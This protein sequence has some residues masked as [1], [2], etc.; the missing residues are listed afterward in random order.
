MGIASNQRA[1]GS[2]FIGTTTATRRLR[3]RLLG[4]TAVAVAGLIGISSP[5]MAQQALPDAAPDAADDQASNADDDDIIV[6]TARRREESLLQVPV[7]VTALSQD[8]LADLQAQ[9]LGG[10]QGAVP[11]LNLVQGRGSATSANIFIRGV[12]QPDALQTFDPAVGVY[13]DG[14]FLSRIQGALLTLSDVER[15]EVLRGPQGTLYG[16][17]TIGGAVNIISRKP[18]LNEF[19]AS[20]SFLY[21]SFDQ[22]TINGYASVPLAEDAVA[23]SVAGQYDNR[24]GIITNPLTGERFNDRDN[25]TFRSIL[26]AQPS[27]SVELSLSGDYTRQRNALTLGSP[28]APIIQTDFLTGPR[29]LVPANQFGPFDFESATSFTNGEGQE[30]DHWGIALTA[31]FQLSDSLELVSITS[32]RDLEADFFIDID[33][34]Q[35]EIGD[36]F[37]GIDQRQW[38]QELQLR[39]S[40]DRL[41]GV[42]GLYYLNERVDSDQQAFADDL[43][44]FGG[45]PISFERLINDAQETDSYAVFGQLT[46]DISDY[47]AITAGLRYTYEEKRYN[48]FTTTVSDLALLNGIDFSFPDDLPPPLNGTDTQDFDAFTPSLTIS[49]TPAPDRLLYASASRGF[50]SGGFNG[51]ANSLADLTLFVD[52]APQLVTTFEPETV[53]TYE[54]GGKASFLDGDVVVSAAVF[55]SDY[56][57]FQARVGGGVDGGAGVGVF[58]VLNAGELEIFGFEIEATAKPIEGLTLA[59]SLGYL[60]A[61]YN[62]FND[63]RRVPPQSFS[64]NPTGQEIICE[65]AFAPPISAR[66]AGDYTFSAGPADISFGGEVRYVD[67]HFLSV[68]N[69]EGLREDGYA[70]L[71][72]YVQASFDDGRYFIRGGARNLT[73]TLYR[74][75]GQEF[76]SVGNIQTVYF[77]DPRTFTITVG[78]NY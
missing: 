71:N 18:D 44:T 50:K 45:A 13:V 57:N 77:G 46:Y 55:Y 63:G 23:L 54:I 4:G 6:V 14:V 3:Y 5:A 30:L 68:D 49:Y 2:Y 60:D 42:F 34:T 75:D 9:D 72:A 47:W 36:V 51:R 22:T 11:N 8:D 39:Y 66:L 52:G 10:I 19:T 7:A 59:T 74:T 48:R 33:A 25:L 15:V 43:F 24:D 27:D 37:V 58:P 62:E 1:E 41:N 61:Q 32:Y 26:R 67:A 70:L 56:Q 28:T 69:R 53:W 21:G 12:G 38:S 17:N 64:C 78:F 35:A 31:N 76:S 40:S 16:K 73:D 20:G 65:P 29:V